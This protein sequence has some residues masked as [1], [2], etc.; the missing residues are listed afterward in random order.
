M[1]GFSLRPGPNEIRLT[2]HPTIRIAPR[3]NSTVAISHNSLL[4]AL[5]V[6][7]AITVLPPT[8]G[9]S[10]H[11]PSV[12][13]PIPPQA[14]NYHI[15]NTLPWNIAIDP[16]TL[17]FHASNT[18]SSSPLPNPIWAYHAPPGYISALGCEIA[19]LIDHGVPARVPLEGER[20]CVGDVRE[21]ELRPYGSLRVRMAELPVVRLG[22]TDDRMV[23][24]L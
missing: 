18:S 16:A 19:W 24:E 11:P 20:E 8:M 13:P 21:V 12:N 5:D 22:G 6:G 2:L 17:V 4:Y 14:H 10:S 23:Q 3:A 15:N 9:L 1:V 7:E